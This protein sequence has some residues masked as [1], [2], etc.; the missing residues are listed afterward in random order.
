MDALLMVAGVLANLGMGITSNAAYDY[1]KD[2]FKGRTEVSASELQG[3]IGDYLII[4]KVNADAG[5]VMEILAKQGVIQVTGSN[6]YEPLSLTMGAAKGA[7]F[8]V[9]D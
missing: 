8:S 7:A 6:L 3:A 4:N 9:G 2:K 1:L 5:T